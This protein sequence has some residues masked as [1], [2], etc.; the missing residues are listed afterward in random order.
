MTI[1]NPDAAHSA[2]D[3]GT[4]RPDPI[5]TMIAS[6]SMWMDEALTAWSTEQLGKVA[7]FAPLAVEHLGKAVLWQINPALVAV[8]GSNSPEEAFVRLATK[9]DLASP[10]LRT[11]GL[12]GLLSRLDLIKPLPVS[13]E[14]RR[15]LVDTRNGAVHVGGDSQSLHV[16]EDALSICSALLAR[17]GADERGFYG[18][19][20]NTVLDL[21]DQKRSAVSNSVA[22]KRARALNQIQ[23]LQNSLGELFNETAERLE[24][25][26]ELVLDPQG[27]EP[28]YWGVN[29]RC[30]VCSMQGRL[31]GRVRQ[32]PVVDFDTNKVGPGEY[33]TTPVFA[34]WEF[35]MIP[36]VFACNVCRLRLTGTEEL[37]NVGLPASPFAA[38]QDEL[39]DGYDPEM[40]VD[41][42]WETH[43]DWRD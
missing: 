11:V 39:G 31:M 30:P 32:D 1:G 22:A 17:A 37:N 15:R 40:I 6:A 20:L 13:K 4:S 18:R 7:V 12:A 2:N 27:F 14:R 19:H 9:P 25:M 34:G 41:G 5:I 10:T 35:E 16:L 24:S 42:W 8:L 21:R 38:T 33:E 23:Q 29:K 28:D 36:A 43:E 3:D 26:A